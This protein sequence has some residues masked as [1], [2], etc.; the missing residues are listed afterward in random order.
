MSLF[1]RRNKAV[2]GLPPELQAYSQAERRERI[3][4][5]WLV[6]IVSLVVSLVV[7]ALLYLGG[8]WVYR[9][10]AHREG[11]PTPVVINQKQKESEKDK[12]ADN[13]GSVDT[14]QEDSSTNTPSSNNSGTQGTSPQTSTDNQSTSPST[15][16]PNT[17]PD[18]DL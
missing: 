18:V 2:N 3:G 9:K 17:G 7:I 6:G 16:L 10:F 4:V 11:K 13:S 5:A 12:E 15:S 8:R 14:P 1:S